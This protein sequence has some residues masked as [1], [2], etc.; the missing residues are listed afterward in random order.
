[1]M[2][3]RLLIGASLMGLSIVDTGNILDTPLTENVQQIQVASSFDT[4]QECLDQLEYL[5]IKYD[6]DSLQCSD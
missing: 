6:V 2:V 5:H 1:M 3:D 4:H